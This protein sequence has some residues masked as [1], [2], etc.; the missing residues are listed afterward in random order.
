[1]HTAQAWVELLE[2]EATE[3]ILRNLT[4]YTQYLFSLRVL[5]PQGVGPISTVVVMTDEGGENRPLSVKFEE[6]EANFFNKYAN[7]NDCRNENID[8]KK[9]P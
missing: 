2:P 7:T 5:N 3:Y 9:H 4:P 1:M 8:R 6:K